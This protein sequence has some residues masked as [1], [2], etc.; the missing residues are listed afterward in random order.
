MIAV[1][2]IYKED[3]L[4]FIPL[5]G[6]ERKDKVSKGNEAKEQANKDAEKQE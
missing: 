3:E 5:F 6:N 4:S 2:F 1:I